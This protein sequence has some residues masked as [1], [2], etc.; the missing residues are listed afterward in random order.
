MAFE[1]DE[2]PNAGTIISHAI[3]GLSKE[4]LIYHFSF[5]ELEHMKSRFYRATEGGL[6]GGPTKLGVELFMWCY[7]YGQWEPNLFFNKDVKFIDNVDI[8]IGQ[9]FPLTKPQKTHD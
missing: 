3:F 7:G 2:G 4:D 1:G 6:M 5:G 9:A 8:V